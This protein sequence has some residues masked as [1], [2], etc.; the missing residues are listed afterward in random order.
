MPE[1][2]QILHQ[3]VPWLDLGVNPD[4]VERMLAGDEAEAFVARLSG[5]VLVRAFAQAGIG[6]RAAL[7]REEAL[8]AI[9]RGIRAKHEPALDALRRLALCHRLV[10][11]KREDALALVG[12]AVARLDPPVLPDGEIRALVERGPGGGDIPLRERYVVLALALLDRAPEKLWLFPLLDRASRVAYGAYVPSFAGPPVRLGDGVNRLTRMF[13]QE[14]IS[15][16]FGVR[17]AVNA[18]H[19]RASA[20]DAPVVEDV[21]DAGAERFV[22]LRSQG[23]ARIVPTSEGAVVTHDIER[24]ILRFGRDGRLMAHGGAAGVRIAEALMSIGEGRVR[25]EP[26]QPKSPPGAVLDWVARLIDGE[27]PQATAAAAT[28]SFPAFEVEIS[29]DVRAGLGAVGSP[30]VGGAR[31]PLLRRIRSLS[32][33]FAGGSGSTSRY[34]IQLGW[35]S[36]AEAAV[37]TYR[38]TGAGLADR[39]AFARWLAD[40]GVWASPR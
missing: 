23:G 39:G 30:P 38:S 13:V 35:G 1:A 7:T 5:P 34:T 18:S 24:H 36:A 31:K 17:E 27:F 15:R 10:S 11:G 37:V 6:A 3:P 29:G 32:V 4:D 9:M 26:F 33:S 12:D 20:I 19:G 14:T 21:V 25:Y 22:F 16:V 8:L 40:R 28:L 2:D